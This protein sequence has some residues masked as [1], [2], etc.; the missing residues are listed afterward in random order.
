[1]SAPCFSTRLSHLLQAATRMPPRPVLL[2]PVPWGVL[3]MPSLPYPTLSLTLTL[4]QRTETRCTRPLSQELAW[5][6][7]LFSLCF[8]SSPGQ[9]PLGPSPILSPLF[10]LPRP[11][12]PLRVAASGP[13]HPDPNP[14][15]AGHRRPRSDR[16]SPVAKSAFMRSA[17]TKQLPCA[18]HCFRHCPCPSSHSWR[19]REMVIR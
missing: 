19:R 2:Q 7:H 9:R 4:F 3:Q 14:C 8:T 17:S 15:S 18:Q 16:P 1:M 10:L 11:K 5:P 6:S 13:G 12:D